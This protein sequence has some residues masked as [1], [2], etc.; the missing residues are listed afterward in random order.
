MDDAAITAI[1]MY[2]R[3]EW[4][5]DA[6]PINRRTVGTTRLTSQGRVMPWKASELK[7][8]VL[9]ANANSGK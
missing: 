2:I 9:E 5:N 1:L 6:G 7:K 4:G 3:N 8:Y